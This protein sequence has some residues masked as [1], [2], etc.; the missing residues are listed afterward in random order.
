MYTTVKRI[1]LFLLLTS[2]LLSF[3]GVVFAPASSP[4]QVST[5]RCSLVGFD[6]RGM[7]DSL[8][9]SMSCR[10]DDAGVARGGAVVLVP[11]L[12]RGEEFRSVARL[13]RTAAGT[14]L[15]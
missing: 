13:R 1:L 6:A 3:H 14:S 10:V 4:R 5:F 7:G 9:I 11:S 8:S 15:N 12:E 2:S